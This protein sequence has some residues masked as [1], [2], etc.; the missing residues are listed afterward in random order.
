MITLSDQLFVSLCL[1]EDARLMNV[2][3]NGS[4]VTIEPPAQY[5]SRV[6][7]NS[8]YL[9]QE[10]LVL[11]P[12]GN[13]GINDFVAKINEQ[14]ITFSKYCFNQGTA[15][16]YFLPCPSGGGGDPDPECDC[17][18]PDN[19]YVFTGNNIFTG[20]NIH[21][22]TEYFNN[23]IFTNDSS[24]ITWNTF[25]DENGD[26]NF[27]NNSTSTYVTITPDGLETNA[28]ITASG[29]TVPGQTGFLRADCTVDD[30]NYIIDEQDPIFNNWWDSPDKW[31]TVE[32]T[33]SQI[34]DPENIPCTCNSG[35][36]ILPCLL[37]LT[38]QDCLNIKNI[39]E[40][41]AEFNCD[42]LLHNSLD[43]LQGGNGV[44]EY[45]HLTA[46]EHAFVQDIVTNG[47]GVLASHTELTDIGVYTHPEIDTHI[48]DT[49]IHFT[50]A[51]MNANEIDPIFT[52]ERDAL[53]EN[54]IVMKGPATLVDSPIHVSD[55][56]LVFATDRIEI[57]NADISTIIGWNA[58]EGNTGTGHIAIGADAGTLIY[59]GVSINEFGTGGLYLGNYIL[60]GANNANNE[61]VIGHAAIGNGSN[62]VTIGNS[63]VTDNY[64]TGNIHGDQYDITNGAFT[65][66]ITGDGSG[67]MIFYDDV[68]GIEVTLTELLA[69]GSGNFGSWE[70]SANNETSQTVNDSDTVSFNGSDNI[71]VVRATLDVNFDLTDTGV[72]PGTYQNP[73]ITVDEKGRVTAIVSNTTGCSQLVA[74][75][76]T[77]SGSFG[78][79]LDTYSGAVVTLGG[80]LT[81]DF[82][83]VMDGDTGH[84]EVTHTG[85]EHLSFS[86]ANYDIRINKISYDSPGQVKLSPYA[87]V[88]VVA[89]WVAL[90]NIH[91]AVIYDSKL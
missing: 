78:F 70:L 69:G 23:I 83:N 7:Q 57:T 39:D 55:S 11:L 33:V 34:T 45:Y 4:V 28:C 72:T 86:T 13:Y 87:T 26:L 84:I 40:K 19:S 42:N 41:F 49:T 15:D 71:D 25:V 38:E 18:D 73:D 80:D 60:S 3:L 54:Y 8:R 48:D 35:E 75:M 76:G 59:D 65:T 10:V 52:A 12:Y 82:I 27:T 67:N 5:L 89:Y 20:D 77:Q 46:A 53:T 1:P 47:S 2:S 6:D 32:I 21:T 62:T 43:G 85:V 37:E 9:G 88:D 81:I 24:P 58:L 74:D 14:L 56:D 91:I 66:Y 17:F 16:Q 90:D 36:D 31:S 68:V 79:D 50:M 30:T 64:F 61:V 51:E 63:N 29:I 44:D 22:G